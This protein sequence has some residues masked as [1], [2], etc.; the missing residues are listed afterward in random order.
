MVSIL[1]GLLY[2]MIVNMPSTQDVETAHRLVGDVG[3]S[4]GLFAA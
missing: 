4:P 1:Q 3:M 2:V